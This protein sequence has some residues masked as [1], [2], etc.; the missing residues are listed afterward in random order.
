MQPT[1]VTAVD[2]RTPDEVVRV[3]ARLATQLDAHL[4][5]V[6][7]QPDPPLLGG[8][9]Q[10]RER[11]RNRK[12]EEGLE[13]LERAGEVLPDGLSVEYRSE[14][15]SVVGRLSRVAEETEALLLVVGRRRRGALV[16]SLLGSVS[17]ELSRRA[18]S[19]VLIVPSPTADG[20]PHAEELWANG[21]AVVVGIDGS[22]ESAAAA[23]FADELA[24]AFGDQLLLAHGHDAPGRIPRDIADG[25]GDNVYVPAV[26]QEALRRVTHRARYLVGHGPPAYVLPD[27]AARERAR[28][29]VIGNQEHHGF[30]PLR[31]DSVTAQLP[32]LGSHP[33]LVVRGEHAFHRAQ[34]DTREPALAA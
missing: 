25:D 34:L 17:H 8:S 6:H 27:I 23:A 2:T 16:T 13:I 29:I 26:M 12:N 9:V 7:V 20:E 21:S 31:P 30:R 33:V 22:E 24:Q 32:R 1:I 15:G 3:A 19:P 11:A 14:L 5:L 18:P 28:M 10:D 4:T